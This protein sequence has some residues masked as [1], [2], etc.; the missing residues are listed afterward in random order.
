MRALKKKNIGV[1]FMPSF[2]VLYDLLD[3]FA[4]LGYE[5]HHRGRLF[6]IGNS[7]RRPP[8]LISKR[9]TVKIR[10][11]MASVTQYAR[12]VYEASPERSDKPEVKEDESSSSEEKAFFLVASEIYDSD[13]K[14]KNLA[15][16]Q[17]YARNVDKFITSRNLRLGKA[18]LVRVV[19]SHVQSG[20]LPHVKSKTPDCDVCQKKIFE[21]SSEDPW[22]VQTKL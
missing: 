20:L 5:E 1:L 19:K 11:M 8:P 15:S 2:E 14:K 3:D 18:I 12:T 21:C 16:L 4:V 17:L 7:G 10:A 22:K 6:F 13:I 9:S